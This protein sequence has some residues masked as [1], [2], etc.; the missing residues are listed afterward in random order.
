MPAVRTR[1]IPGVSTVNQNAAATC[2]IN[3]TVHNA[4]EKI[5]SK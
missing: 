1:I 5:T 3:N 4:P 2:L